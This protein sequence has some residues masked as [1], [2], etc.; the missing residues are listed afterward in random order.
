ML[1]NGK[2][3]WLSDGVEARLNVYFHKIQSRAVPRLKT[4]LNSTKESGL[5]ITA[6]L[7]PKAC[8][9]LL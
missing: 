1:E 7:P 3:L 6:G 4:R 9:E 5:Q 2:Q 8:F